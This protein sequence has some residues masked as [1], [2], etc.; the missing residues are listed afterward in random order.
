MNELPLSAFTKRERH[1][2]N[3][4]SSRTRPLFLRFVTWC[5]IMV[6]RTGVDWRTKRPFLTRATAHLSVIVLTLIAITLSGVGIPSP[7]AA[8]GGELDNGAA[9]SFERVAS[10]PQGTPPPVLPPL[11]NWSLESDAD[12]VARLPVP[13]TT[14][15]ERVR[16]QVTAY[17]VQA[18]DTIFDIAARYGLAPDTIVWSNREGINDAPWLIQPG[19]KLFILPVDGVYHTVLVGE[20]V[21]SIAAQYEIEPAALYNQWND[22]EEGAQPR[23]GQLLVVPG[24]QGEEVDWTPPPLYPRPGPAGLS[25]GICRGAAVSGPGGSGS[26][27]YPTGSPRVSGWR[28]HDPR[29]PTHIGLDYAC[30]TGDPLYAADNGVV[31]IAGWNGGYGILIE[32][33][34]GNGFVTRYGHFSELA[35]GCGQSVYQGSLLGY[36]GSTG[37]SSGAHLHFEIRH[38]GA[39]QNPE[40][41]LP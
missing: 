34:H 37:W 26:F 6:W 14:I 11:T 1:T 23:E 41:Y 22:L 36:C 33:N 15:P 40:A 16:A 28:F 32:I 9:P 35:V 20:S 4:D 38:Q 8:V 7:R 19:L 10:A 31:T 21:A 24:G 18:G 12:V 30:R 3:A 17:I 13:H 25:Y 27:S 2:S 29:N 5:V 39:P